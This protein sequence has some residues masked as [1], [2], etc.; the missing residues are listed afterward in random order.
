MSM[1]NMAWSHFY[2]VAV[3]LDSYWV[4]NVDIK[5]DSKEGTKRPRGAIVK[6]Q[7]SLRSKPNQGTTKIYTSW[8]NL[9]KPSYSGILKYKPCQINMS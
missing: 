7:D 2:I 5:I 4:N 3:L 6:S 8:L 1:I 9:A